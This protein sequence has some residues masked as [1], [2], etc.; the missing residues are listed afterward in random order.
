MEERIVELET[1]LAFQEDAIYH[2]NQTVS[3]QQHQIDALTEVLEILKQ[4]LRSLSP[5]PL[6]SEGPEPP[7]PH[8]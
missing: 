3:E 4:R 6:G 5:S 1:R 2:L 8:Y 7:P